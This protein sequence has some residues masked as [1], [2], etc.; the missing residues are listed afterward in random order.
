M[1][2]RFNILVIAFFI[3]LTLALAWRAFLY[4]KP[5]HT[6]TPST[7]PATADVAPSGEMLSQSDL[8]LDLFNPSD[9]SSG[10]RN[11]GDLKRQIEEALVIN[12]VL[13]RCELITSHDYGETYRALASYAHRTGLAANPQ[14][15][16]DEINRINAAAS[17]T[18]S[19]IYAKT[20]CA[21][22]QLT[23]A[24]EKMAQ[25]RAALLGN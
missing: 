18:Y 12:F 14:A 22:P 24:A 7:R 16:A 17:A 9:S 21:T 1:L 3:L 10:P 20:D 4:Q 8:I 13:R 2:R 23:T 11:D 15:A 25:W 6:Y 5:L 19:L